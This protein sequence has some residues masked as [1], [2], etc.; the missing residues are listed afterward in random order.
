MVRLEYRIPL[1]RNKLVFVHYL[2]AATPGV[3]AES[4]LRLPRPQ[5]P[6]L[7]RSD[8]P[9][10]TSVQSP[11]PLGKPQDGNRPLA[12]PLQSRQVGRLIQEK[13]VSATKPSARP[14]VEELPDLLNGTPPPWLPS[15][16]RHLSRQSGGS[17]RCC[18]QIHAADEC[19][20]SV[21][22]LSSFGDEGLKLCYCYEPSGDGRYCGT[23]SPFPFKLPDLAVAESSGG[24]AKGTGRDEEEEDR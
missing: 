19:A 2:N 17:R 11:V 13:K 7:V 9:G 23:F 14:T 21:A 5:P 8:G 15:D 16:P 3:D 10:P 18:G 22:R 24:R 20:P 1:S 6:P 4:L 12:T